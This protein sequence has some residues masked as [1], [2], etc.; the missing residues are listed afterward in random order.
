MILNINSKAAVVHTNRMEKMHRSVIPIAI[1]GTLNKA[2]FNL[3]QV[4]MPVSAAK[5]F[6]HRKPNFFKANSKV[7]MA[8]GFAVGEMRAIAG[9]VSTGLKENHWAVTEL[10]QQEYGGII[11]NRG[12]VPL[13]SARQSDSHSKPIRPNSRLK[14]IKS[15]SNVRNAKGRSRKEKFIKTAIHVGKGGF[16][17][18]GLSKQM[19]YKIEE[20]RRDNGKM[21]IKKKAL[22]SYEPGR[23]VNID[24][25][26]FMREATNNSAAN[27]EKFYIEEANRQFAKLP[28]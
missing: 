23:G 27:L 14:N 22:Y 19:L 18:G 24:A 2:A 28:K 13:D 1:R 16:M 21:V 7:K 3:K 5:H 9:F 4:T 10:E 6:E 8:T 25:T 17:I 11:T 26:S 15:I 20:I 12:F